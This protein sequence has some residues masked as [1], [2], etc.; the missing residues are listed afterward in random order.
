M[1]YLT[2]RGARTFLLGTNYWSRAGGPRMWER[3][4]E[5]RVRAE[6]AQMRGIGLNVCRSFLFAPTFMPRPPAVDPQALARFRTLLDA[7]GAEGLG[8]MPSLVVGHMSGENYELPGQRGR[9]PYSDPEVLGWERELATR[10]AEAARG[11]PAVAAWVLSNEMPLFGGA[12]DSDTITA[13]AHDLCRTLRAVDPETPIGTGDGYFNQK[14][15]QDGFDPERLRALVDYLGPHTYYGDPDPM[16]QAQ[17]AEL[18]IRSLQHLGRPVVL[19][20]FGGSTC[21]VSEA[22]QAA[23][24]REVIHGVLSLGGAGAIGW[25]FSDFDLGHEP[26]YEH[27]AFELGFGITRADGTEKPVCEDLRAIAALTGGLPFARLAFPPPRAAIIQPSYFQRQ[28][29]FSAEDR[30]RMRRNLV[31]AYV[32]ALKAG[33]EVQ[34][35]PEDHDL[36]AFDLVLVPSTQKLRAPTWQRLRARAAAG[37]TVY[38]SYFAGDHEFHFGMWIDGFEALTGARHQLRYGVPD[39]PPDE[40]TL[41]G[42]GPALTTRTTGSAPFP[43]AFLP[44]EARGAETVLRDTAGRPALLRH[45]IGSGQ[46][47]FLAYPWE[48]YLG[49]Q[50]DVNERDGSHALYAHLAAAAGIRPRY[51]SPDPLVQLRVVEDGADDLVWVF[52]RSWSERQVSLDLPGGAGLSLRPKDVRVLRVRAR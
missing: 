20:E 37:G 16:R 47:F 34:V 46:V 1:R 48:H 13:W 27:H 18:L 21:Q 9:S 52:N 33:V 39:L 14:G 10:A 42:A 19:E 49:C 31:Q 25:C 41:T 24:Y 50:A 11:A 35:V 8:V 2:L 22:N 23:Y 40:V 51:A 15:G 38:V 7:C 32:L 4:D 44:V 43:R 36:D 28:Y 5:A 45:A 30:G 3:F 12:A 29:P 17:S 6:I 26:P